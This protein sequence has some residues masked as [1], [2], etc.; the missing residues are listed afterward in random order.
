[1]TEISEKAL[2]NAAMK[3]N[4]RIT[5]NSKTKG[6]LRHERRTFEITW[7]PKCIPCGKSFVKHK[8]KGIENASHCSGNKTNI[9]A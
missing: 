8:L 7:N 6:P 4:T 5:R 1:M 9:W 2:T 3:G